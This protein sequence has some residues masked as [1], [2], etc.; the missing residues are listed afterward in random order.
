MFTMYKGICQPSASIV[1]SDVIGSPLLLNCT[2]RYNG[3]VVGPIKW[4]QGW[5][6]QKQKQ[7]QP[8]SITTKTFSTN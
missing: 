4:L 7:K 1:G 8:T 2:F 6:S 3:T 5:V